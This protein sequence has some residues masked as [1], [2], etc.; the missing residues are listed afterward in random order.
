MHLDPKSVKRYWRLDYVLTLWGA[1]GVKAAQKKT[2]VK[3]TPEEGNKIFQSKCLKGSST[4]D[5]ILRDSNDTFIE[6]TC[7]Q[8]VTDRRTSKIRIDDAAYGR[9]L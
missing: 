1:T 2:L 3:L 4:N 7:D 6:V 8:N 5:V 9:T